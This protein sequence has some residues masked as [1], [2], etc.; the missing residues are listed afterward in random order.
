[1]ADL[2]Q[3]WPQDLMKGFYRVNKTDVLFD[4]L[5]NKRLN[6]KEDRYL[7]LVL[8]NYKKRGMVVQFKN[9][10]HVLSVGSKVSIMTPQGDDFEL[11]I[12]W[13]ENSSGVRIHEI[14]GEMV[15]LI[16]S[17]NGILSRSV[18]NLI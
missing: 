14:S 9:S 17:R 7:G 1:M 8:E 2:K 13:I 4:K 15:V 5:K 16:N 6:K 3:L 10:K 18:I 12:E 11:E